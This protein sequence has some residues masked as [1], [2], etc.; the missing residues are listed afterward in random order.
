MMARVRFSLSSRQRSEITEANT[1]RRDH[2]SVVPSAVGVAVKVITWLHREV[3]AREIDP[4]GAVLG[5]NRRTNNT[6]GHIEQQQRCY[7]AGHVQT[8]LQSPRRHRDPTPDEQ[9]RDGPGAEKALHLI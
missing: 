5:R 9:G 6:R 7:P 2:C 8:R 1:V 4:P 3:A